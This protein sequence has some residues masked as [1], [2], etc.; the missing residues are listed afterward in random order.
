MR[1]L[2]I[3]IFVL[4]RLNTSSQTMG[5]VF[6]NSTEEPLIGVVIK[7]SEKKFAITD[8]LGK[9]SVYTERLP[10]TLHFSF[11]GY[12]PT[13]AIIES[14]DKI[15]HIGLETSLVNISEIIISSTEFS[16]R[17]NSVPGHISLITQDVIGFD[18]N[19]EITHTLNKLPGIYMQSGSMNTNR[20]IIRG[21]GSRSPYSTNRVKLYFEDIPL[22]TGEGV[23]TIG[24][25]D[26]ESI[27]RIE[28]IRGPASGI[29][30]AGLGGAVN[31]YV[32]KF[33]AFKYSIVTGSTI[34]SYG[35]FKNSLNVG[36]NAGKSSFST[37]INLLQNQGYRQNNQTSRSS[38]YLFS[39]HYFK[40]S[41]LKLFFY[42][43]NLHAYIPSSINKETYENN[44]RNAAPNWLNIK[45]YEDYTKIHTGI[46]FNKRFN[47]HIYNNTTLFASFFDQYESRPFNIL[48]DKSFMSGIKSRF[49]YNAGNTS[50]AA[51]TELFNEQYYWKLSETLGGEKGRLLTDNDETRYYYNFF[52]HIKKELSDKASLTAG[53]NYSKLGYRSKIDNSV[54]SSEIAQKKNFAPILSPRIGLTIK[55]A[56]SMSVYILASHGFSPPTLE[57]TLNPEG[58]LNPDI[59][60]ESGWNFETGI[61]GIFLNDRLN[62]E[63]SVYSMHVKNLLVTKRITEDIFTGINA[64]KTVHNGIEAS[65]NYNIIRKNAPHLEAY[66][67][68]FSS[69]L[70][71]NQFLLFIDDDGDYAGNHLPGIPLFMLNAG[72]NRK[73]EKGLNFV[74]NYQITGPMYLND[75]NTGRTKRFGLFNAKFIYKLAFAESFS[76]DIFAGI[77]NI[78]NTH[79]ASMILVNAPVISNLSPRYYYPGLPLNFNG[80]VKFRFFK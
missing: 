45:G 37:G 27:G 1:W 41:Y 12:K 54:D 48:E 70:S 16:Q 39:H 13:I 61:R 79:Y 5:Y 49:T 60:P 76:L 38:F 63:F 18:N 25:I 35:L 52:I 20:L 66:S 53:M 7:T 14:R 77:Y 31:L 19:T 67:I 40:K 55:P 9:F 30:G 22:T 69:H 34:G 17:L 23:T 68:S 50:F 73:M 4:F 59:K 15:L 80:G 78:F 29:Y 3:Y 8:S 56:G 11:L 26:P 33:S 74:F 72:I 10:D 57:E 64:G 28:I 75:S 6:D 32:K 44:P 71:G 42:N 46:T 51:G 36:F 43:I 21:I 47:Y 65:L 58:I 62:Y 24:D 2:L